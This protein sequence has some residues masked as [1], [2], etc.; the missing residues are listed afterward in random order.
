VNLDGCLDKWELSQ[1]EFA[2]WGLDVERFP[3]VDGN[4]IEP[5]NYKVPRGSV[6]NCLSKIG[7]VKLAVERNYDSVLILE[8][9]VEFAEDFNNKFAEWSKEVPENW[10]MLWIGGNH[11]GENPPKISDHVIK[12][13]N[14]YATHAFAL[15]NTVFN[16]VLKAL[17]PLEPQDDIILAGLQ[18]VSNSFCFSPNLACQRAGISDVFKFYV[19]YDFLRKI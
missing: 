7:I 9:D 1:K 15:R 5:F 17:E 12:I 14:T 4:L 2:K 3:A 13:T 16:A 18:K 19:D 6:G 8:D 11:N 10:D